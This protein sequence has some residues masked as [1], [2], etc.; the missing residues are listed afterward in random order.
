MPRYLYLAIDAEGIGHSGELEAG[1]SDQ[2]AAELEAKGLRLESVRLADSRDQSRGHARLSERDL[3]DFTWQVAGLNQAG[4]AL[5]S[6]LRA[7]GAEL[8][9]GP[10][11]QVLVEIAGQL[12]LGRSL[13]EAVEAQGNRFPAHLNGL[14]LAGI[15]TG[16]LGE[17]LEE[18][19]R[20]HH[21][22]VD[23]RRKLWLS[24]AYPIVLLLT[25]GALFLFVAKFIVK[26]F[27]AIFK[28]FGVDVPALT[29]MVISV[30]A[31]VA[32]AGWMLLFCV[33]A[34]LAV[35]WL[36][37]L[38][39]AGSGWRR[40]L[41]SYLP[42]LGP[43]LRWTSLVEFCHLLGLLLESEIALPTA[44]ELTGEGMRDK[45]IASECRRMRCDVEAGQS[46]AAAF[47]HLA[48]FPRGL[49]RIML[50]K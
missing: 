44:L 39:S 3:S 31:V 32:D 27:A 36:W 23:L 17:V 19:A 45:G 2:V 12:E 13:Q 40:G 43:L 9:P 15:K 16:K 24:M 34:A 37:G 46:L 22:S 6:G 26:E 25:L 20:Y 35:Y 50:W 47:T 8:A 18:F 5:H 42:M 41:A 30:S 29:R 11:R 49:A 28:D 21:D 10:L 48:Q 33:F 38:S 1:A 4:S 7:L 14:V